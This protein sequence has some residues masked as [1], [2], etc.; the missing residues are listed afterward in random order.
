MMESLNHIAIVLG[1]GV[2]AVLAVL[3]ITLTFVWANGSKT[4]ELVSE[5]ERMARELKEV[6]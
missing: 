4:D 3:L 1:L 5:R 6:F 2:V